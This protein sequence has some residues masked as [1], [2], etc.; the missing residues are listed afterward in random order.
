MKLETIQELGK[1]ADEIKKEKN[2]SY[3]GK[4]LVEILLI[5]EKD[6]IK[7]RDGLEIS[8]KRNWKNVEIKIR[9]KLHFEFTLL[10]LLY[11]EAKYVWNQP[12]HSWLHKIY[13]DLA[14]SLVYPL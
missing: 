13:I 4:E 11:E 10:V 5:I 1:L 7:A 9:F 8:I 3:E 14:K 12:Y 2:L 6:L